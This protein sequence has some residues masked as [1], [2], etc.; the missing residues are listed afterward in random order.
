MFLDNRTWEEKTYGRWEV[1]IHDPGVRTRFYDED[2][3]RAYAADL[4]AQGLS[5]TVHYRTDWECEY[6]DW[7]D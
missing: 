6:G 3:A 4:E 1:L 7:F 2:R 5:C